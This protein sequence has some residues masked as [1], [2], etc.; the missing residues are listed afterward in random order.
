[1]NTAP[2]KTLFIVRN[3]PYPPIGG[4]SLRI[5]QNINVMARF[6]S[7]AVFS[8]C[9]WQPTQASMPKV[10]VWS[11]YNIDRPRSPLE[12]LQRKVW[13]LRPLGHPDADW[14]YADSAA[15]E[16][17]Q[18]LARF[19]PDLVIF[20]EVWM[21]RYLAIV[22][23]HN[24]HTILV[25]HNV[26][27]SLFADKFQSG[28]TLRTRL[29][30]SRQLPQ[31]KAIER[32]F[33]RQVDQ[34]WACSQ[35]DADLLK[36][37]YGK[38]APIAIIPNGVNVI[39]YDSARTGEAEIPQLLKVEGQ[40]SILFLGQLSYS[41][42]IAAV[43]WLLESI[44]PK[45]RQK[46]PNCQLLLV[47]HSP[48]E[49][50]QTEAKHDPTIVVTGKV[51]DVRP[52]LGAASLM[53][54]PL[55]Q[56]GGTRLKILEAFAAGCPVVSTRKG[57]EGLDAIANQ[58]LLIADDPESM[59]AAIDQLWSNPELGQQLAQS[60]YELV[61]DQYSWEAIGQR[62]EMAIKQLQLG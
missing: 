38:T 26:E 22:K 11:H 46:Y 19:Q 39:S 58:H 25:E 27:A 55:Q 12:Q 40:Q 57:A 45:L 37:L 1:M 20:E 13:W 44:Y 59:V 61:R 32:N 51:P 62:V 21:Y 50:M 31:L 48:T 54:V 15:Q 34:V 8:A 47:G 3:P 24:C 43:D 33:T 49:R 30:V 6:G 5:W 2:L 29:K 10:D 52:Y 60:A 16:L 7:V 4:L 53:V 56:G 18:L 42:N 23:Q 17:D 36:E 41:P 35:R 28:R 9:R 14:A